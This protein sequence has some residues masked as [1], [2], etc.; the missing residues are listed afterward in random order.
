MKA[1]VTTASPMQATA[2]S[3]WS[4]YL[5]PQVP[6]FTAQE[7]SPTA[8]QLV[9]QLSGVSAMLPTVAPVVGSP[10]TMTRRGEPPLGPACE[11]LKEN[12]GEL[13]GAGWPSTWC[14]VV[15]A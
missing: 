12:V 11:A 8:C 4:W 7:P 10:K 13:A 1:L 2:S 5:K 6:P 15:P 3:Y 14:R 9:S